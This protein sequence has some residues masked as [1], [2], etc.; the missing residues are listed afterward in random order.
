ML[1]FLILSDSH[2]RTDRIRQAL[3]QHPEVDAVLFLGDGL[4]DL[5]DVCEGAFPACICVRGNCDRYAMMRGQLVKQTEEVSFLGH[6][7]LLTHGDAYGV[8]YSRDAIIREARSRRADVVLF[9]HT[10][11]P[12]EG[13]CS[14]DDGPLWL[15]NPGNVGAG[16]DGR[17]T[18]GLLTLTEQG[19]VL[20]SHA[21]LR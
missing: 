18:Y 14:D 15:F 11:V 8:K 10:H 17:C 21:E 13:Y 19:D 6:R 12:Y 16:R 3:R 9:G 1:R 5:D 7:L 4:C 20:F 2:G